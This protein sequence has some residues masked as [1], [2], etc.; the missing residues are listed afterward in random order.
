M[1]FSKDDYT[2]L[3]NLYWERELSMTVIAEAFSVSRKT[4]KRRMIGLGIPRRRVHPNLCQ[5][6]TGSPHRDPEILRQLYWD[7]G[8]NQEEIGA[9][10]GVAQ[11]TIWLWMKR[12]EVPARISLTAGPRNHVDLSMTA[13]SFLSGCLLGDGSLAQQASVSAV[14]NHSNKHK[15]YIKWLR[16]VLL[17]FNIESTGRIYSRQHFFKKTGSVTWTYRFSTRAYPELAEL[18]QK[19]YPDGKKQPPR[20]LVLD[21]LTLRQWYLGDGSYRGKDKNGYLMHCASIAN[22]AFTDSDREFLL[23]LIHS[24]GIGATVNKGGFYI[25]KRHTD[26]FFR[27]I[28]HCPV[29]SIYGYKWPSAELTHEQLDLL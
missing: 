12:L 14:Y 27:V 29:P 26:K 8:L 6:L 11:S 25:P 1:K 16:G 5:D 13:L 7:E 19:W 21:G 4:I 10:L 28:G 20:D 15:E 22:L 2:L 24:L 18:R 9:K 23:G 3:H 17:S